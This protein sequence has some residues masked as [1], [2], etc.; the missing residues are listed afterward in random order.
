VGT[1][2]DPV[3]V[4]TRV[5]WEAVTAVVALS[6][7]R[8]QEDEHGHLLLQQRS[9]AAT[10][11]LSLRRCWPSSLAALGTLREK[12]TGNERELLLVTGV[13]PVTFQTLQIAQHQ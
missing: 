9:M 1:R 12:P 2:V 5:E 8:E 6:R 7:P 11:S 13:S 3:E 4:G 10:L